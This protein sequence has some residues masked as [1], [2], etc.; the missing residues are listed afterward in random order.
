MA[1]LA[2][3]ALAFGLA[4]GLG[5]LFGAVAVDLARWLLGAAGAAYG[6]VF[7]LEA[8]LFIWSALLAA[9]L[10]T[11]PAPVPRRFIRESEA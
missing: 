8:A 6:G 9:R 11:T 7:A 2:G 4:F 10:A 5:G 3:G 1:I